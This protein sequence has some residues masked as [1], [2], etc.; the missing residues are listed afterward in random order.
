MRIFA[1]ALAIAAIGGP[2]RAQDHQAWSINPDA[3]TLVAETMSV[4]D[5]SGDYW[6]R[7]RAEVTSSMGMGGDYLSFTVSAGNYADADSRMR[8]DGPARQ[9]VITTNTGEVF[10]SSE[11]SFA[12]DGESDVNVSFG[13]TPMSADDGV[14]QASEPNCR[15]IQALRRASSFTVSFRDQ[16][17]EQRELD[18]TGSGSGRALVRF[19]C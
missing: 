12:V 13:F 19:G 2:V 9:V 4:D 3:G 8:R 14:L 17:G 5:V 1:L 11:A 16:H 15:V 6:W 7:F 10:R 18:F